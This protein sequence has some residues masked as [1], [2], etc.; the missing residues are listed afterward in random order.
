MGAGPGGEEVRITGRCHVSVSEV[1]KMAGLTWVV[2]C[3]KGHPVPPWLNCGGRCGYGSRVR[4][5]VRGVCE[6]D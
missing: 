5:R 2:S 3:F 1:R 4:V 6:I